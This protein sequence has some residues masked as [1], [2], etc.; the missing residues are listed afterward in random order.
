MNN[1]ILKHELASLIEA[2]TFHGIPNILRSKHLI[3]K[4]MWVVCFMISISCCSIIIYH[5]S[6]DFLQNE[7]VTNID[8]IYDTNIQF[9]TVEFCIQSTNQS[10][11]EI[12]IAC[13]F[14]LNSC[15][16]SDFQTIQIDSLT[17]YLFNY[18]DNFIVESN[19]GTDIWGGLIVVFFT[20]ETVIPPFKAYFRIYNQSNL[21]FKERAFNSNNRQV[22]RP[23]LTLVQFNREFVERLSYPFN[24]CVKQDTSEY[25]S[26]Y[27]HYF[28]SNN[29]TYLQ[30]DCLDLCIG[31]RIFK[32]CNCSNQTE[33][34]SISLCK[35]TLNISDL[36]IKEMAKQCKIQ[37]PL[38]CDHINYKIEANYMGNLDNKTVDVVL[39]G[40]IVNDS[41]YQNILDNAVLLQVYYSS[42]NY[43]YI[44][45]SEKTSFIDYVSNLGGALGLFIGVSFLSFFEVIEII[46][47]LLIH[48]LSRRKNH[49]K[50]LV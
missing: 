45:Q 29:F 6:D 15:N 27:F 41:F 37:C 9:P 22:L 46:L 38:E 34:C 1:E 43:I 3:V 13:L 21:Y 19:T 14:N 44:S 25:T 50:N 5:A 36:E 4:V 23:G 35:E 16:S 26:E 33:K 10:L 17:C 8:E 47:E 20:K 11:D 32:K 40:R 28:V 49:I 42:L 31:N 12:L 18:L 48:F 2:S 39:D 7:V 24:D 30:R